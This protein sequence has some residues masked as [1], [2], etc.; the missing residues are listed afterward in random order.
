[1]TR[2]ILTIVEDHPS[3]APAA[4]LAWEEQLNPGAA[5]AIQEAFSRWWTDG[6]GML[7][8]GHLEVLRVKGLTVDIT[9]SGDVEIGPLP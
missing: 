9:G 8:V 6:G 3:G 5:Q 2:A 7:I 1:M 4:I